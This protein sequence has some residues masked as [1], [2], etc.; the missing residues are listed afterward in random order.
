MLLLMASVYITPYYVCLTS[1]ESMND[2][3]LSVD[4]PEECDFVLRSSVHCPVEFKFDEVIKID[5]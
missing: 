1:A 3:F 4:L 5:G 2:C